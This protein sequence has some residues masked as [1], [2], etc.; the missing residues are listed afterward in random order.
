MKGKEGKTRAGMDVNTLCARL[1][2]A[3]WDV[4]YGANQVRLYSQFQGAGE[5]LAQAHGDLMRAADRLLALKGELLE[6]GYG[7]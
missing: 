3:W 2:A 1:D 4:Q 5:L 6:A 7:G